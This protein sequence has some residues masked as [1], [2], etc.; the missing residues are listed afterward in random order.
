MEKENI[1]H[2]V[3]PIGISDIT[4]LGLA[5]ILFVKVFIAI[6]CDERTKDQND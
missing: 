4:K 3:T 1:C 2:F 5:L 6:V